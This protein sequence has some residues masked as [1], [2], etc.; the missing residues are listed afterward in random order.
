MSTE[1]L[2]E[3]A[4][5]TVR[6]EP[7]RTWSDLGIH[8]L[9]EYRDLLYF[10]VWRD[11]KVRYKQTV[12]GIAWVAI[13]PIVTAALFALL[14][15]RVAK[16]PSEGAPYV[17][18]VFAALIPWQLFS[19]AL[20]RAGLSL[21]GSANL[22]TKVY[23]PRLV[24]P[25]SAVV[26]G[27]ADL[28]VSLVVLVGLVLWYG[29]PLSLGIV[30]LP[31]FVLIAVLAALSVGIWLAALNVQYRDVQQALPFLV[32]IWLFASPVAYSLN[33][34]PHGY[35]RTIY[36]LNPIVGVIQGFRWALLG[37][38]PPDGSVWLSFLVVAGLLLT[39]AIY[40]RHVEDTF[41]DVV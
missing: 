24:I 28:L 11:V 41:A 23:F 9:W 1:P 2:T 16:L 3:S 34:V 8:E 19:N 30:A 29:L 39:G 14:M 6:I 10:L 31:V 27:L 32:Q 22:V 35:I 13:Q 38:P 33:V 37:T 40:F 4:A 36:T 7:K 26:S 17:L 5:A 15:G 25:L 12:L 20:S 21:V 18:F